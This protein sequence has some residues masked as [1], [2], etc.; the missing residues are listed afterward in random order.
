[1]IMM[2]MK[3]IS[4]QGLR[5]R[6]SLAIA[7]LVVML[8]PPIVRA[9]QIAAR[10]TNAAG[11]VAEPLDLTVGRSAV[12]RMDRPIMRVSLSTPEIADALV[13]S[14]YELLV[15]GKAPGTISLLVWADTG[16]IKTYDVVVR[17]DLSA[18]EGQVRKLFPGEPIAV[19]SNGKDVVLS[20]TVSSKYIAER[21]S[22]LAVG[23]VE[24]AD[25]VVNLLRQQEG[26]ATDQVLLRVRFA[27]VSRSAMQELGA[28][29]FTGFNGR[30]GWVGRATTQQFPA[31]G[32][33]APD[34]S[35]FDQGLVFSDFLNLFAFNTEENIGTVVRALKTRGL[36]QSLAEPNLIT[37]DGKEASFLAGGE[38]PYPVLQGSGLNAAVTIVFKEFGIRLRFT[39]T[40]LGGDLVHL[41]VLPEVSALDFSNAV[42]LEGF[43]VPALTTRR[44]ET[45][46]ELRDG[47]TFA[48]AG[49]L[50][51]T[52]NESLSRVPGIGDIPILGYLFRSRAYQKN[53]TELVVM[54]TPHIVRR[55]SPGLTPN[56]PGLVQPFLEQ[57][58]RRLAPPPPPFTPQSPSG[59]SRQPA[60]P[61]AGT[62]KP[63]TVAAA[64]AP[65]PQSVPA[66]VP[67]PVPQSVP[68]PVSTPAPRAA[69]PPAAPLA[70]STVPA[71]Q[72]PTRRLTEAEQRGI[73]Q[74]RAA[75]ARQR[76]EERK[77]A[78]Q[79]RKIDA[80]RAK[81]QAKADAERAKRERE[82]LARAEKL[83]QERAREQ[84]EIDRK[85]WIE[86]QKQAARAKTVADKLAKEQA[87]RQ[88][89]QAKLDAER[90]EEERKL[91]EKHRK[92]EEKLAKERAS[93]DDEL[94][95]LLVQYRTLTQ[96]QGTAETTAPGKD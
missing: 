23:Y 11:D 42:T 10:V 74:A 15:H 95:K 28:S 7:L 9:D 62:A 38:Y 40:I 54:I 59:Q 83:E 76:Q 14:P 91:A 66:P 26:V 46:V 24:K 34:S 58:N 52:V 51:N 88:A 68:A 67:A 2:L 63:Q 84:G 80:E 73:E 71:V 55:D 37:Q 6:G 69:Q 4:H 92:A 96:S 61:S 13:T 93:R 75:E 20:G 44:T 41:K 90:L 30:D 29:W 43:R 70:G 48:I 27:E 22:S 19:A 36:F 1:M 72:P 77:R 33:N 85:R 89:E 56:L 53:T 18:L 3:L 21:A 16:R 39:P 31:P 65:A 47:Q 57:P 94:S 17:R 79:L 78:E 35:A 32:F 82:D 86:Q 50:D 87:R 49:L 64:P 81:Q 5:R 8:I 12:I 25:N 60:G 45:D